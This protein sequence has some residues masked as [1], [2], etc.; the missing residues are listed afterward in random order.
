M[1]SFGLG[2]LVT[3]VFLWLVPLWLVWPLG[4]LGS[5]Y[6]VKLIQEQ[7]GLKLEDQQIL[8]VLLGAWCSVCYGILLFIAP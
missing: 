3:Y 7:Q 1:W 5:L 8:G 4:V 2:V 6:L